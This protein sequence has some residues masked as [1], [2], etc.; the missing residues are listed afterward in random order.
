MTAGS[1]RDTWAWSALC[2]ELSR[3]RRDGLILYGK[4]RFTII[5]EFP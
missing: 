3:M 5:T 4:R 1:W 2:A